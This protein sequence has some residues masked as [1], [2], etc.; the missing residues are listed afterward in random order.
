MVPG[1]PVSENMHPNNQLHTEKW[2]GHYTSFVVMREGTNTGMDY[3]NGIFLVFFYILLYRVVLAILSNALLG[4]FST[5]KFFVRS[6]KLMLANAH[7]YQMLAVLKEIVEDG[8]HYAC[9]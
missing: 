9:K 1:I 8:W 5:K 4:T 7:V 6:W 2:G 3:W